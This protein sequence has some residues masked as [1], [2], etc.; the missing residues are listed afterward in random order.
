MAAAAD[1]GGEDVAFDAEHERPPLPAPPADDAAEHPAGIDRP[2][3]RGEI[4]AHRGAAD[5]SAEIPPLEHILG[6]QRL[7]R[8]QGQAAKAEG[9]H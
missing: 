2:T 9:R 8:R 5:R 7:L 6:R 3:G 1:I 4:V